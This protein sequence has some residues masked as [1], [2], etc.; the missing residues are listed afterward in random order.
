MILPE[1]NPEIKDITYLVN[2]NNVSRSKGGAFN[3]GYIPSG[4]LSKTIIV[5]LGV[6]G[7]LRI[8]NVK[9]FLISTGDINFGDALFGVD[10]LD[11]IDESYVPRQYFTGVNASSNPNSEYVFD[12]ENKNNLSSKYVYLNVEFPLNKALVE[13]NIVYGWTFEYE[14]DNSLKTFQQ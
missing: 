2:G 1:R 4:G 14:M 13:S 11:Y 9:L 5:Y 12:V 10:T 6:T 8:K 7:V 3:F